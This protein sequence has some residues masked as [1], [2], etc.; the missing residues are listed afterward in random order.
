MLSRVCTQAGQTRAVGIKLGAASVS[1]D[2]LGLQC[3]AVALG[4]DA[5]HV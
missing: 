4:L 5:V 3:V 2:T 1:E